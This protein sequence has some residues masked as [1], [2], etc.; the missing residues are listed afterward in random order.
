MA[1]I[2]VGQTVIWNG[3]KHRVVDVIGK[4]ATVFP[5]EAVTENDRRKGARTVAVKKLEVAQ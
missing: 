5:I 2:K 4:M 1:E 3:R